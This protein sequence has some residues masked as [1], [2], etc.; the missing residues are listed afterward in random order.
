MGI[1]G[2][3]EQFTRNT[4]RQDPDWSELRWT[5][6]VP[7]DLRFVSAVYDRLYA[8]DREFGQAAIL[9]LLAEQPQLSRTGHDVARNAGSAQ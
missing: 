2:R 7:D 5:V 6:D 3:P 4:V 8:E 9:K 1:Y